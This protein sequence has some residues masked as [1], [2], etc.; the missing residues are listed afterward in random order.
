M[1]CVDLRPDDTRDV[2]VLVDGTWY[3]AELQ[4]YRKRDGRWEGWV[5]WSVGTGRQH[6][7]WM[8][9]DRVRPHERLGHPPSQPVT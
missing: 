7:D 2:L 3:D 4:A 5:R 6:I 1:T 8:D 9:Q